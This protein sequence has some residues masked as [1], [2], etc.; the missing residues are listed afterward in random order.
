MQFCG[1]APV[2]ANFAVRLM[3]FT[4]KDVKNLAKGRKCIGSGAWLLW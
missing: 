3:V 1:L 4:A 2:F